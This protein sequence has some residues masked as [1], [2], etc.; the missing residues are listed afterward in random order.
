MTNNTREIERGKK[1]IKLLNLLKMVDLVRNPW[2]EDR[3]FDNSYYVDTPIGSLIFD[4]SDECLHVFDKSTNRPVRLSELQLQE[5]SD[6]LAD[7]GKKEVIKE[8]GGE[9][10]NED[11]SFLA[12][13]WAARDD[14]IVH[15]TGGWYGDWYITIIPFGELNVDSD[16]V[17]FLDKNGHPD[18]SKP[19]TKECL[20]ALDKRLIREA[21]MT[22]DMANGFLQR[23]ASL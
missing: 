18:E 9:M 7:E 4:D 23:L 20:A 8:F 19:V 3:E 2:T 14:S 5:L 12:G 11:R 1:E 10:T 13:L 15:A 16:G 17:R 6:W 21:Q 22:I